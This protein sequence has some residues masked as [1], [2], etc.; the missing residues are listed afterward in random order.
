MQATR[1]DRR[2][3]RE[4][5]TIWLALHD[6]GRQA[7][8][9]LADAPGV[10]LAY[11]NPLALRRGP[12]RRADRDDLHPRPVLLPADAR[13]PTARRHLPDVRERHLVVV[14]EVPDR[15]RSCDG[16][17][18]ELPAFACTVTLK[19]IVVAQGSVLVG[20]PDRL[21]A[22][23]MILWWRSVRAR[24]EPDSSGIAHAGEEASVAHFFDNLHS[25]DVFAVSHCRSLRERPAVFVRIHCVGSDEP[26]PWAHA[27]RVE[28]RRRPVTSFAA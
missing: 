26:H 22:V 21:H 17:E 18:A 16:V 4:R 23:E 6:I 9:L 14:R 12:A 2:H 5:P 25:P 15:H 11:F 13:R 10:P 28:F 19:L 27:A 1:G 7:S 20:P 24:F 3:V 8:D